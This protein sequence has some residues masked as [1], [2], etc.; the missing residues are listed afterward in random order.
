MDWPPVQPVLPCHPVHAGID[1]LLPYFPME[2]RWMYSEATETLKQVKLL[3]K[4]QHVFNISTLQFQL[5]WV[6]AGTLLLSWWSFELWCCDIHWRGR[7]LNKLQG[8]QR[9]RGGGGGRKIN[10]H[11]HTWDL[12]LLRVWL[13][14]GES[15]C[16]KTSHWLM[17]D[18][19]KGLRLI[20]KSVHGWGNRSNVKMRPFIPLIY[21]EMTQGQNAVPDFPGITMF[22][23]AHLSYYVPSWKALCVKWVLFRK[24]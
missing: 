17:S 20:N 19:L 16:Y 9:K 7:R 11:S 1:Y 23:C 10:W 14:Q 12:Y 13:S 4:H 21:S 24:I 15:T 2:N 18:W 6:V 8:K 3:R 5:L 22:V